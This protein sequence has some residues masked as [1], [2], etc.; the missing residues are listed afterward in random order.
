MSTYKYV[1]HQIESKQ[2]QGELKV[3]KCHQYLH[4]HKGQ[5]VLQLVENHKT[6]C[7]HSITISEQLQEIHHFKTNPLCMKK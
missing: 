3:A 1:R 6:L 7:L 5:E 4:I 2:I